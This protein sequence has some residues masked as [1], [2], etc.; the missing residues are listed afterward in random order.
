MFVDLGDVFLMEVH[1]SEVT[2]KQTLESRLR[3]LWFR[4]I[5]RCIFKG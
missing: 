2:W 1:R 3:R 5:S 4:V